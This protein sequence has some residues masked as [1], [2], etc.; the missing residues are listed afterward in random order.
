LR[1][2]ISNAIKFTAKGGKVEANAVLSKKQ[3]EITVSD[4]GIGMTKEIMEK[5]FRID[6]KLSTRGTENE[7]GTGLGL[8]LCKEFVEKHGGRISVESEPGKGSIF[9]II[10]PVINGPAV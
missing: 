4:N 2:L 10:L 7:K 8:F 6:A 3:V 9:R 1:N 5:L